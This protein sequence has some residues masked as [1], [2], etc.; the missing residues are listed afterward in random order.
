MGFA[1]L[2]YCCCLFL[3]DKTLS[4]K[5][6]QNRVK[7]VP[8]V[9]SNAY[10]TACVVEPNEGERNHLRMVAWVGFA[11]AVISWSSQQ[12]SEHYLILEQKY[13]SSNN[14]LIYQTFILIHS[15]REDLSL[16]FLR[17]QHSS[18]SDMMEIIMHYD[19]WI[20]AKLMTKNILRYNNESWLLSR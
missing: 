18:S 11:G 17:N 2:T 8:I 15:W 12:E 9:W 1:T 10:L 14:C 16:S 7:Y 5:V 4:G 13:L 3:N 20:V 19:K 6:T